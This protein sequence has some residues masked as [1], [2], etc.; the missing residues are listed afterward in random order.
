MHERV[1][2]MQT[3]NKQEILKKNPH[4][5]ASDLDK[6]LKLGKKLRAAGLRRTEY[7]LASPLDRRKVQVTSASAEPRIMRTR[8]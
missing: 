8:K 2:A 5:D 3:I 4:V 7:R 1:R 6:S